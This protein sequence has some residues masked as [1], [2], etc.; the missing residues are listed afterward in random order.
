MLSLLDDVF[1]APTR[2]ILDWPSSLFMDLSAS[3][4]LSVEPTDKEWVYTLEL[5]GVSKKDVKVTV[6]PTRL[7]VSGSKKGLSFAKSVTIGTATPQDVKATLA[8]GVLT[9]RVPRQSTRLDEVNVP[10]D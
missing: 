5:P 8:D 10:I 6:T 2:Q 9:I 3:S 7:N 1:N 4:G